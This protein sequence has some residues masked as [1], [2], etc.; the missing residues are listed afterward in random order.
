MITPRLYSFPDKTVSIYS[1]EPFEVLRELTD[2]AHTVILTDYHIYSAHHRLFTDYPVIKIAPGESH[3]TQATIDHIIHELI[4]LEAG[5]DTTLVGVGGGVVTDLAGFAASIYKR[6]TRLIL[7]PTSV[8]AMVDAA[9]GGKNGINTGLYKNTAGTIYQPDSI[10]YDF[11]FLQTLPAAE[12][13]NGF[14]EVIKHACIRDRLLFQMLEQYSLHDIQSDLSLAASIIEKNIQIKMDIVTRDVLEKRERKLLNFGHTI[15]HAIENLHQLPHGHAVSIGMVSACNL[16]VRLNSFPFD[17]A[18]RVIK[19]LAKLHLPVDIE[20]DYDKVIMGIR[21]DKKR[22][23]QDIHFIMLDHI[24]SAAIRPI[25][26]TDLSSI[27]NH[28]L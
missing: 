16:S 11:R 26:V 13:I 28:I 21:Q 6:G 12:W 18:A 8:L 27:I 15:G 20:T 17:E 7:A 4:K 9:L 5:K 14:A 23:D 2:P 10:I 3:K 19:L 25:P 24:G 1:D 22:S